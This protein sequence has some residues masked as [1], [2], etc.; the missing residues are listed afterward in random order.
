MPN[1]DYPEFIKNYNSTHKIQL[2]KW[3]NDLRHSKEDREMAN[4]HKRRYSIS[5]SLEKCKSEPQPNGTSH[6]L[7]SLL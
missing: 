2:E 4:K 6:P 5:L 3:A 7:R 1:K